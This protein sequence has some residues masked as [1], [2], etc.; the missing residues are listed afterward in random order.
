M[1][2]LMILLILSSCTIKVEDT[3]ITREE[4]A[5]AFGERDANIQLLAQKIAELTKEEK[6]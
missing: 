5:K 6:K 4:L 1:K 2:Y 3:R